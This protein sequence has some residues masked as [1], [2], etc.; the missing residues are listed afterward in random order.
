MSPRVFGLIAL[1]ATLIVDQSHKLWMLFV[2]RISDHQPV[3][4]GPF[5]DLIVA[6]NP[7]ISYSLLRATTDIERYMLLG[8][9][10]GAVMLLFV[11]LWRARSRATSLA[12]GL[13][14][15]GAL[16]NA[17]DRWA[18]GAVADF[19]RFHVG[20]LSW[21]VFNLADVAIVAGVAL[22]LLESLFPT[23]FARPKRHDGPVLSD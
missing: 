18:Y 22:L 23:A 20:D 5:L 17:Y 13:I 15:G 1:A 11:W 6:W 14:I 12:L 2:Y 10:L 7:G 21:Y 8:L 4:V 19:F 3:H 9:A 16:G